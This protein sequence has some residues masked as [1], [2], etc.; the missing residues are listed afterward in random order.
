M[1]RHFSHFVRYI[2]NN[3]LVNVQVQISSDNIQRLFKNY[4]INFRRK[5]NF[6]QEAH[7]P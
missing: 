7:R 1:P 2:L 4:A 3:I 5:V 6:K